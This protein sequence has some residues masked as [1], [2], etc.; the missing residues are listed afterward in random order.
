MQ[1]EDRTVNSP[2]AHYAENGVVVSITP[3]NGTDFSLEELEMIVGGIISVHS[4]PNGRAIVVNDA[5]EALKLPYNASA[6]E[7]WHNA[8]M[9]GNILGNAITCSRKYL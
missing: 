9:E 8:R 7:E 4:M 2:K 5:A 1:I 6:T 3:E